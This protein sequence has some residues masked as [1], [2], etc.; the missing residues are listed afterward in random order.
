MHTVVRRQT[1]ES[2]KRTRVVAEMVT[3]WGTL[4]LGNGGR[5][6]G[7]NDTGGWFHLISRQR[8]HTGRAGSVRMECGYE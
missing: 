6:V 2:R 1:C 4:W 8:V 3:T 7:G 5:N